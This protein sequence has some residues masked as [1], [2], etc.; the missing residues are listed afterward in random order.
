VL[1]RFRWFFIAFATVLALAPFSGVIAAALLA[2]V[3]GCELN[4]AASEPCP[5]F[6][7]DFG[8]VLVGLSLTA[9]LGWISFS[10][11]VAVLLIWGLVEGVALAIRWSRGD[12]HR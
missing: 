3:L 4:D 7:S 2:S 9:N 1:Y 8:P 11:L 10:I 12:G 5:A 6:G